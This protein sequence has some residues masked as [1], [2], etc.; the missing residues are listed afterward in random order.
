MT[1]DDLCRLVD[2]DPSC[3]AACDSDEA[4]AGHTGGAVSNSVV[5]GEH[6]PVAT[7]ISGI[8]EGLL[9]A[10]NGGRAAPPLACGS[11][12]SSPPCCRGQRAVGLGEPGGG[13]IPVELRSDAPAVRSC[14]SDDEVGNNPVSPVASEAL[15]TPTVGGY[16]AGSGGGEGGNGCCRPGP[17][18]PAMAADAAAVARAT[19]EGATEEQAGAAGTAGAAA[20]GRPVTGSLLAAL[21]EVYLRC[22][23]QVRGCGMDGYAD[24]DKGMIGWMKRRVDL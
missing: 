24:Q 23:L 11:G 6:P 13:R 17:C 4:G 8:S 19:E 16:A 5:G 20:G 22:S 1:S 14:W 9:W 2:L 7:R 18:P 3:P 15:L 21:Y 12:C 10:N